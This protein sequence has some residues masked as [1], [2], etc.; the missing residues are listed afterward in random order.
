MPFSEAIF[1]H[2][3]KKMREKKDKWV[4]IILVDHVAQIV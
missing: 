4:I 2:Q 1:L 3:K